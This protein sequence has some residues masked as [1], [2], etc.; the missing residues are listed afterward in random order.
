MINQ[1]W[2]VDLGRLNDYWGARL[3]T[4]VE[5]GKKEFLCGAQYGHRGDHGMVS[6]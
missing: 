4:G 2:C 1:E 5:C 3:I 6:K